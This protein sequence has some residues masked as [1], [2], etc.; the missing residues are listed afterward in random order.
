MLNRIIN[1]HFGSRR[2]MLRSIKYA[3]LLRLGFYHRYKKVDFSRVERLVFVCYGNICRSPFAEQ[4][5]IAKGLNAISYGLY[6]Q[7]HKKT[8]PRAV[9]L[10]IEFGVSLTNHRTTNIKHYES[11]KGDLV[12][13]MEPK[14]IIDLH[15]IDTSPEQLT[16]AT[17][18]NKKR[19]TYLH[20]PYASNS[21]F[22]EKC[23]YRLAEAV[24]AIHTKLQGKVAP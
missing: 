15:L 13:V 22:F 18:W 9:S 16:V 11:K 19:S 6:C 20:D 5:A 4:L 1:N 12:V 24:S 14:H 3:I 2:G 8:D 21:V 17:L 23:G 7:D 10:A